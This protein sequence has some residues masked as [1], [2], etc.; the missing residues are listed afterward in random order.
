MQS[1]WWSIRF[2]NHFS[3]LTRFIVYIILSPLSCATGCSNLNLSRKKYW[4]KKI[5]SNEFSIKAT[6][7]VSGSKKRI[8]LLRIHIVLLVVFAS[9]SHSLTRPI[10]KCIHSY[11][12]KALCAFIHSTSLNFLTITSINNLAA[13]SFADFSPLSLPL[14]A[15]FW[16][17][18]GLKWFL[19]MWITIETRAHTLNNA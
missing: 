5:V 14:R 7:I 8:N 19:Q 17:D 15:S 9:C 10:S 11:R 3:A 13:R 16:T 6:R 1:K 2:L 18:W 12:F 4:V